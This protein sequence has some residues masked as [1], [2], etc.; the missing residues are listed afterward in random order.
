M[1]RL[2][3]GN[4]CSSVEHLVEHIERHN[5]EVDPNEYL[6]I[7]NNA[8]T[9]GVDIGNGILLTEHR[10][11]VWRVVVRGEVGEHRIVRSVL[12]KGPVR[13]DMPHPGYWI[14]VKQP[15]VKTYIKPILPDWSMPTISEAVQRLSYEGD[16]LKGASYR[17]SSPLDHIVSVRK[18]VPKTL[19]K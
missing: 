14:K 8:L 12:D 13:D 6:H 9:I 3:L 15:R 5:L 18:K 11:R 17:Y 19:F 16:E 7:A 1:E 4:V 10:G 2:Y